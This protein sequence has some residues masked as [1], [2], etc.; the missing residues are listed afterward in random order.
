LYLSQE[1]E[2][3]R[4]SNCIPGKHLI[5]PRKNSEKIE[6]GKKTKKDED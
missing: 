1:K 2:R 3:G 5:E 6:F 4:P